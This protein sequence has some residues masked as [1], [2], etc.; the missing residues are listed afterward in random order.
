MVRDKAVVT[1]CELYAV[2]LYSVTFCVPQAVWMVI[3]FSM[4]VAHSQL[5]TPMELY[6][7]VWTMS[8]V[9]CVMTGGTLWMPLL[10]VLS[11]DSQ[12]MVCCK[13]CKTLKFTP[14]LIIVRI[15]SSCPFW[16]G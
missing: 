15:H 4:M 13:S 8:M 12:L 5:T 3:S 7:F 9:L 16:S 2:G 11:W 14:L 6:W 1:L 10:S